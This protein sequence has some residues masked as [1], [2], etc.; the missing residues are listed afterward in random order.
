MKKSLLFIFAIILAGMVNAQQ[1]FT[2]DF[3]SGTFPPSGWM[4]FGNPANWSASAT[5]YAGGTAPEMR[6]TGTPLFTGFQ[7]IISPKINTTGSTQLIFRMKH[8]FEHASGNNPIKIGV[9]TRS[10]NG[11]WNSIWM[12]NA[13]A[14]IPAQTL[15]VIID[16]AN[17]GAADFQFCIY[18]NGVST[19]LND[20]YVDDIEI[21]NPYALDAA[22][23]SINLP[24]VF[25]GSQIISGDFINV[26]QTPITSA[27]INW[28]VDDGEIHTESFSNFNLGLGE[29]HEFEFEDS[30][31]LAPSA[32]TFKIWLSAVNGGGID[33]NPANDSIT[34][35]ISVL[36]SLVYYRPFFEEFTSSTCGPCASFNNSF[37]NNFISTNEDEITLVKYQ[38]NWPGS[39]DPYYTPEG[40]VR[41][42]Y[43]GVNAV[44]ELYVDGKKT[45]TN[46]SAVNAA[47]NASL[48]TRAYIE[49]AS[50]HEIQGNNIIVDANIIP[51]DN[52]PS[53]R[54]HLAVIEKLTTQNV[55]SNGETSFHH[56]MMKMLP[57][58]NGTNAN[59]VNNQ[60]LNLKFTQ[61][62]SGTH[63][64]EMSDLMVAIFVQATDK[65]IKQSGY[66]LEVGASTTVNIANGAVDVPVDQPIIIDFSQPVRRVG[67]TPITSANI[68]EIIR[69]NE[70]DATGA[71]VPFTATIN[72]AKTQ[73]VVTPNSNLAYLQ[74]YYFRLDKLENYNSVP[75]LPI[76]RTFTTIL[77]VGVPT[78]NKVEYK[79]YPNPANSMIYINNVKNL[80]KVELISVVGNIVRSVSGFGNSAGEAGIPVGNLPNG[81]YFVRLTSGN[82]IQ[83]QRIII[84]K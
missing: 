78:Q 27:D 17:V 72:S 47:F 56:V 30:L 43:Y 5:N 33:D 76:V 26:G 82:Q 10:A 38:M 42:N 52:Y 54:V 80:D 73:I 84:S 24:D 67:G 14:S 63:V 70:T 65:T 83:T 74:Q 1:I 48:G 32:Y 40:G 64:E 49:I 7:R 39:G 68:N 20:W 81:M 31:V 3:G 2:Q 57:N 11:A 62:M 66:S 18:V 50:T 77:N 71:P 35:D 51:F 4:I 58:A 44:P 25:A 59:L 36:A 37:F 75:T 23:G 55:G 22:M 41:R 29:S 61:D 19:H 69:F 46:S 6:I 13:M 8:K 9:E 34:K 15:T 79:L 53:V 28:Q 12:E 21:S 60:P 16:N 45:A